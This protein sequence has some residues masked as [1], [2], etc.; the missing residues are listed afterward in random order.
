MW[1][2]KL[3]NVSVYYGDV[4]AIKNINLEIMKND[5]LGIIGPNGSG[6]TTLLK[7]LLGIISPDAGNLSKR[8]DLKVGYVPQ[9]ST[10]NKGFPINVFDMVLM[11]NLKNK[12]KAFHKFSKEDIERTEKTLDK[13]N[14]SHLKDRHISNLSGGQIQ[15]SLIAR[16][17]V[18]D[19][20]VLILD[21]PT[22][23]LDPD[24]K[25]EIYEILWELNK[26]TTIILVSHDMGVISSYVKNVA[27]LNQRLFYHGDSS[28]VGDG[29]QMAY[30]C[31]VEIIAHGK[32]H[33]V[34][35][36]HNHFMEDSNDK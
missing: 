19:P 35:E 7:V 11:G 30:G 15:K 33:R 6:K 24:A 20:D 5:F 12:T 31:P 1:D 27:C 21:E 32:P 9:F 2:I 18:S 17:I 14:I 22:A 10:F 26:N 16:A 3:E 13:I 34:F 36:E 25:K 23:S 29:I 8:D 4:C 28:S